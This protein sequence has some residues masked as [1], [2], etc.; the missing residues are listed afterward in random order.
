MA[1]CMRYAKHREEAEDL[2]QDS[3]VLIFTKLEKV[4]DP[5][6]MGAWMKRI[7]VNLCIDRYHKNKPRQFDKDVHELEAYTN[8]TDD[9]VADMTVQE[10]MQLV[11]KLPEGYRQVFNLYEVEGYPHKEIATMLKIAEGTSKSQLSKA[12]SMLR[13]I[14]NEHELVWQ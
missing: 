12:K 8:D 4:K 9:V 6:T 7:A 3:M 13:K 10:V 1:V 14:I 5:T 11:S 2:F